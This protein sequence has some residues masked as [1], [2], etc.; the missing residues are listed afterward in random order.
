MLR[1]HGYTSLACLQC[2]GSPG[3]PRFLELT[4]PL[5]SGQVWT[6][7]SSTRCQ[8]MRPCLIRQRSNC[9]CCLI[10]QHF[11]VG[12]PPWKYEWFPCLMC[13]WG[14][15]SP[16]RRQGHKLSLVYYLGGTL[17]T[18]WQSLGQKFWQVFPEQTLS[19]IEFQHYLTLG[20]LCYSHGPAPANGT[21]NLFYHLAM[22]R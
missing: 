9:V 3:R 14:N 8:H 22:M 4:R 19:L 21:F 1:P 15:C 13:M 18:F 20:R 11:P 10:T 7:R 16:C 2:G 5:D 17:L 6:R 12:E